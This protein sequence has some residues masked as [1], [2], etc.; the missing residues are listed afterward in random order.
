MLEASSPVSNATSESALLT[1]HVNTHTHKRYDSFFFFPTQINFIYASLCNES[2]QY[3]TLAG[4]E[5]CGSGDRASC[6]LI[7]EVGGLILQ[8][9]LGKTLNPKRMSVRGT[10]SVD[11]L[12]KYV[13]MAEYDSRWKHFECSA[14]HLTSLIP[15]WNPFK[16]YIQVWTN[17]YEL[18]CEAVD[19]YNGEVV[20]LVWDVQ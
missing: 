18:G 6:S 19:A 10:V 15:V 7:Q 4:R 17:V 9:S 3:V 1:K 14:E 16:V 2:K 8:L 5:G 20:I 12:Y 11:M 13:W